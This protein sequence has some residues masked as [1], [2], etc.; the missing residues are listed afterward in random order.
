MTPTAKRDD[1]CVLYFSSGHKGT[2]KKNQINF[3]CGHFE[4]L[5]F[6][7]DQW[8]IVYCRHPLKVKRNPPLYCRY[9]K[10]VASFTSCQ[11]CYAVAQVLKGQ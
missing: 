1:N 7:L 9:Q 8:H 11:V 4:S 3:V 5:T 6:I 2:H 10:C